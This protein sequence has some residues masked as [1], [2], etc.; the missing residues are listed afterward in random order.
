M[1]R[2]WA[3]SESRVVSQEGNAY[4]LRAW[5]RSEISGADALDQAR[6]RLEGFKALATI[7][8]L[9]KLEGYY[10]LRGPLREEEL[11]TIKAGG[12]DAGW[13]VRN[14][15]GARVLESAAVPMLDIDLPRQPILGR[16]VSMFSKKAE[17]AWRE[18]SERRLLE[19]AAAAGDRFGRLE[20]WRTAQGWRAMALQEMEIG[21]A[22]QKDLFGH[23]R[24]VGL[25][26]LYERLCRTQRSYR[27]RL[28]PKPWRVG[29][30][31]ELGLRAEDCRIDPETGRRSPEAEEFLLEYAKAIRGRRVC[32]KIWS[33]VGEESEAGRIL[34]DR[35]D[36][37]ACRGAGSLA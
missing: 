26:P 29:P 9:G 17:A 36:Q 20:I 30:N 16:I 4:R 11:E 3:K 37:E 28:D 1:G 19:A 27:A 35:H 23:F 6:Q 33:G 21:S 15:Y 22:E 8:A 25:D 13:I 32:E 7:D 2:F 31:P 18:S 24:G 12:K 5:G 14:R 34:R 10:E